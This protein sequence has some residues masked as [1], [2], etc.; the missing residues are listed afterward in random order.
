M[1]GKKGFFKRL[2]ATGI[3]S[4]L[5]MVLLTTGVWIASHGVPLIGIPESEDIQWVTLKSGTAVREIEEPENVKLLV[6]AANLLNYRLFGE[7][8]DQPEIEVT[9]HLINGGEVSLRAGHTAMWWHGK[10][11]VLKEKDVFVNIVQG[12]FFEGKDG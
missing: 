12:L 4:V 10:Q 8:A 5:A 11:H 3:S 9:Y 1:K 6:Q 7:E 2:A